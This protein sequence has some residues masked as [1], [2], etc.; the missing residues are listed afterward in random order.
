H[1]TR[2]PG[3]HR[4]LTTHS[5]GYCPVP[6]PQPSHTPQLDSKFKIPAGKDNLL[7]RDIATVS[8][9]E[10]TLFINAIRSLDDPTSSFVYGNNAGNEAADASGNI[11]YWDMQEQIHKD[12]HAHGI[13]VHFGPAFIPWHRALI[14][15]FEKLL[16][17]VDPHLSLHYWDWTTDPRKTIGDRVDLFTTSF[18]GSSTGNAGPPLQDFESTEIT[19]DPAEGIPGDGVHDHIWR[20]VAATAANPNGTP[21]LDP[22]A[23]ILA[24]TDFTSFA[25][26]LKAAHDDTAHSYIGGTLTNAHFSFHD[27]FVFL[28]HSNLDRIWAMW[29][30]TPGH[31]DRLD[32]ARACLRHDRDRSRLSRQLLRRARATVGGGGLGG[33]RADPA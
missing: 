15:H 7:R 10:R 2:P 18:I 25:A 1:R 30:R 6:G 11:T 21:A 28:L 26:S 13:N 22:D 16:R 29:Q 12:G 24:H 20:D 19:G 23:T 14:N 9:E 4:R 3:I 33:E 32:P 17:D 31:Q 8:D 5:H 27:P